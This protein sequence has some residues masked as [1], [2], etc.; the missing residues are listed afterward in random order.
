M[1]A[2]TK[3][4]C[5]LNQVLTHIRKKDNIKKSQNVSIE[6]FYKYKILLLKNN[7]SIKMKLQCKYIIYTRTIGV[8]EIHVN[9]LVMIRSGRW[10]FESDWHQFKTLRGQ[11]T[12]QIIYEYQ[13]P[14]TM[15]VVVLGE[16]RLTAKAF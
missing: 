9:G 2:A 13:S 15:T 8:N 3:W 6:F 14:I 7:S 10:N 5:N 12:T 11:E 1:I 4:I 16:K